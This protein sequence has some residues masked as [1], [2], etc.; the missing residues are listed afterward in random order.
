[1]I[2]KSERETT[3]TK[4]Y[5]IDLYAKRFKK[6][7]KDELFCV[8]LKEEKNIHHAREDA[9][10]PRCRVQLPSGPHTGTIPHH[11]VRSARQ[12]MR[13]TPCLLVI[14]ASPGVRLHR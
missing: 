14:S 13:F 4:A 6:T 8:R 7:R 11:V 12:S 3:D 2:H 10:K 9:I 5:A 1:M